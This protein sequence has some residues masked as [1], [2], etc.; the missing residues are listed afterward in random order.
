MLRHQSKRC[1]SSAG[2]K[3][4]FLSC[5]KFVGLL[6]VEND[7]AINFV[8]LLT[9]GQNESLYLYLL[10]FMIGLAGAGSCNVRWRVAGLQ[11]MQRIALGVAELTAQLFMRCISVDVQYL[12]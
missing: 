1:I 2:V 3:S 11:F 5:A 10:E 12:K 4:N 7:C 6:C 8:V 9:S